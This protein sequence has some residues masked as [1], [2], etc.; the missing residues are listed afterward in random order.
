MLI[1]NWENR[2]II[3]RSKKICDSAYMKGNVAN[4]FIKKKNGIF[5]DFKP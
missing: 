5:G 2:K 4:L 1:K 3:Q